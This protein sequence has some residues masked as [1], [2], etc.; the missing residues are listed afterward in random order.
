[1]FKVGILLLF[2]KSIYCHSAPSCINKIDNTTCAGFPRYYHFNHLPFPLSTSNTQLQFYSSRDRENILQPGVNR[3]CPE[4]NIE[5]YTSEFPMTIAHAG[6]T[7]TLQHPPRGHAS[8]PSSPVWIYLYNQGNVFDKPI[9][10]NQSRFKLLG[11]YN[12]S[13]CVGLE[14]EISWANCTGNL[15]LPNNLKDAVYTFWWRWDLNS[16]PYYDCFEVNIKT[17]N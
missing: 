10:L 11:E 7:L 16:I 13:N 12:Y 2:V 6:D 8:Q 15:H 9:E 5:K 4:M 14:H 3:I 1:M 17:R